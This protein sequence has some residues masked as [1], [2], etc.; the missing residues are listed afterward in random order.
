V[1]LL[2]VARGSFKTDPP[3]PVTQTEA[4]PDGDPEDAED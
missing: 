3:S 1:R 2:E 4:R